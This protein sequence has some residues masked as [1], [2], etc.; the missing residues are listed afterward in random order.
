MVLVLDVPVGEKIAAEPPE[1]SDHA[2]TSPDRKKH[3][4]ILKRMGDYLQKDLLHTCYSIACMLSF[5]TSHKLATQVKLGVEVA[6]VAP[7]IYAGLVFFILFND[8]AAARAAL[9]AVAAFAPIWLPFFLLKY[10]WIYWIHY[11]RY[12]FWFAQET[13][14]LE[15]QLPPQVDKSPLAMELF[16]TAL[17]NN[18][19]EVTFIK[20]M[21]QGIFRQVWTLEI[22]SMEGSV[23]FYIHMR[24]AI[25]AV[26]EARLYGQYPEA[27]VREVEDYT[28]KIPFN[29]EEYDM[30]GC[31]YRKGDPQALPIKTYVDYGLDKDPKEEFKVD[32]ITSVLEPFAAMGKGEYLWFQIVLKAYKKDEWYGFYLNK[33]AYLDSFKKGLS[34]IMAEASKRAANLIQGH[35]EKAEAARAQAAAR[36]LTLLT[37]GEKI[38]VE[39]MERAKGKLLFECG[40]RFLYIA[41]KEAFNPSKIAVG[42]RFFDP[43]RSNELNL[44]NPARWMATLDYPWQDFHNIR[45]NM[46]KKRLYFLFQNRA[47]FYVPLDQA[48]VY[49]NV[50]ELASIWH[51]PS[52]G[53]KTPGLNRVSSKLSEA[54]PDIPSLPV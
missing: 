47:Y 24:K 53:V 30:W 52:S 6:V 33:T 46:F 49:L 27:Q 34:D 17:W 15:I 10:F 29:I 5:H 51:F 23:N 22:S 35:D 31:E 14:L 21:W 2:E 25:R 19:G 28:R 16:L 7:I 42:P 40:M 4:Y 20:R 13:V 36:G 43:F 37:P 39:A 8:Y 50:E 54:P 26:V 44:I 1:K 48:P 45:R 3:F 11:V 12:K 38:K 9:T 18:G 32:P 41:K